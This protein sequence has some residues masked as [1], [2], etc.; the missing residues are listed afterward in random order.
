MRVAPPIA[1]DESTRKQLQQQA[2]RRSVPVRVALRSR[3][4]LL[5]A[6]GLQI[7]QIGSELKISVR[8]A[9]LWRERF[10][11][12]GVD[13]LLKDGPRPGRTPA[14]SSA[15]VEQVIGKTTQTTPANA[16]HWS[17]R[18]M[19]REVGSSEASVRRIWRA[20]GL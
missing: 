9:A 14:I 16:T 18:T 10:L 3:I 2:R 4:V 13:G 15:T 6:V 12:L 11:S 19:A 20:H 8:M 17:T 7:V 5:A 1:L